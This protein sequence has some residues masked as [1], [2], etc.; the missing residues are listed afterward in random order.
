MSFTPLHLYFDDMK[1]GQE[2][3]S[4]GRTLTEADLVNF[5]GLSGDFNPIHMDAEFA[6]TTP[7]RQRIAHGALVFAL[8]TGLAATTP[9]IRTIAFKEIREWQFKEPAFIGD[10]IHLLS[11]V[12]DIEVRARGRRGVVTWYR[13]IINQHGKVVQQGYSV[14]LVEGRAAPASGHDVDKTPEEKPIQLAAKGM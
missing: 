1:V 6:R 8:A 10:T 7:F 14:T 4:H 11:R 9:P 12:A 3:K 2:W 13:Q 5:A